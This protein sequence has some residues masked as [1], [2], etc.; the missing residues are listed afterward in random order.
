MEDRLLI[1]GRLERLIKEVNQVMDESF[2][3]F[4]VNLGPEYNGNIPHVLFPVATLDSGIETGIT[5]YFT[6]NHGILIPSWMV[7][8]F[9]ITGCREF[10]P[11]KRCQYYESEGVDINEQNFFHITPDII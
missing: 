8:E 6:T 7:R 3:L 4:R 10:E 2:F 5:D 9:D 11:I 1:K